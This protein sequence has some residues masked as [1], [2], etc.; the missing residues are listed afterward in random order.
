MT[1]V[2]FITLITAVALITVVIGTVVYN[3]HIK[4]SNNLHM[5]F[6]ARLLRVLIFL[7]W[8]F[9]VIDVI[10]DNF[11]LSEIVLK[12][13]AL[14]VAIIGFAAQPVISDLIGGYIISANKPFEIGDR[15]IIEGQ[16]PG[17]VEDITLRHTVIRI[18]KN[19]T[20]LH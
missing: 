14:I 12:G 3:R 11:Q 19:S 17:I 15:I 4:N 7:A 18:Y 6:N 13:S 10:F 5:R 8:L 9:T 2:Q 1:K 16:Q 20:E